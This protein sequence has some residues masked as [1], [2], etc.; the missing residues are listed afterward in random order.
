MLGLKSRTS[1]RAASALNMEPPVS[2]VP[3]PLGVTLDSIRPLFKDG[4]SW[5]CVGTME[6]LGNTLCFLWSY[7]PLDHF[8]LKPRSPLG[9]ITQLGRCNSSVVPGVRVIGIKIRE[10]RLLR[11][12]G[13]SCR[14]MFCFDT[15]SHH[16]VLAGLEL[17]G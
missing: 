10:D 1:G 14:T 2:P 16:V 13:Y 11:N 15:G 5:Q 17:P 4:A 8:V 3:N 12:Q 9:D 6:T 7:E